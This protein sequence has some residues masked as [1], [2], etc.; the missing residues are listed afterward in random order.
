LIRFGAVLTVV[1]AAMGLLA[2]GVLTNSLLLVYLAIA[3]AALSGVMLAVGV[4]IWRGDIFGRVP[5]A[6]AEEPVSQ[7]APAEA[8]VGAAR[9][10]AADAHAGRSAAFADQAAGPASRAPGR[11]VPVEVPAD[12]APVLTAAGSSVGAASAPHSDLRPAPPRRTEGPRHGEDRPPERPFR[13]RQPE[14][15]VEPV[16]EQ[17]SAAGASALAESSALAEPTAPPQREPAESAAPSEPAAPPFAV[18]P[19]AVSPS[20]TL[21]PAAPSPRPEGLW[22]RGDRP[23]ERPFRLRQPE[24]SVEP[25]ADQPSAAESSALA[26]PAAPARRAPAEPVAV[27]EPAWAE[28]A[29][30]AEP[31]ALGTRAESDAAAE[32]A[33]AVELATPA[34]Q[35]SAQDAVETEDKPSAA[36]GTAAE[37]AP[38][39]KA[40][41]ESESGG[42]K[43]GRRD[44]STEVI[45]VPGIARYHRNQC[46]LIRFLGPEDLESMT[47][48]AAEEAGCVPC[49]A[50]RPEQILDDD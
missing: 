16:A 21:P 24:W 27:P 13:L 22:G 9:A 31:A 26:E 29:P 46:I 7:A 37:P 50:C 41:A 48:Q 38:E 8:P 12:Q 45:I 15:P 3:V 14:W 18:S 47:M 5:A 32:S 43:K 6:Q 33:A 17:P 20:G 49:K 40:E 36:S 42:E 28:S 10:A 4:L 23:P 34:G 39:P 11:A 19:S 44:P 30:A 2:A 1:L 25:A 35:A